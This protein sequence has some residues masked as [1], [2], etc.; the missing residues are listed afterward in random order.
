MELL[1][2]HQADLPRR[3]PGS[4]LTVKIW[5]RVCVSSCCPVLRLG[6]PIRAYV[7]LMNLPN[8]P[9]FGLSPQPSSMMDQDY[10]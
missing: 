1:L 2:L 5:L 3:T 6:W 9:S 8:S 10:F 7:K 4:R